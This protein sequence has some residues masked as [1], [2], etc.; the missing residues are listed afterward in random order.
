M[1][2]FTRLVQ[3]KVAAS[4]DAKAILAELAGMGDKAAEFAF[5]EAL[6]RLELDH[7]S[8]PINVALDKDADL[9]KLRD[10]TF[11]AADKEARDK[12]RKAYDDA[13]KAKKE[14]LPEAKKALERIETA[15]KGR[16][17]LK[18]AE[19]Q[20]TK[21]LSAAR[22][23]V[24]TGGDADLKGA[25]EKVAAATKS[26][27]EAQNSDALKAARKTVTEARAATSAK[28]KELLAA[29][30]EAAALAKE[31]DDLRTKIDELDKQIRAASKK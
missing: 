18:A 12:A 6:A 7:P 14:A 28:V 2:A 3:E 13:R 22:R 25:Q 19:A 29:N 15:K 17:D 31:R 24:E 16:A 11:Q 21:N 10:A 30:Q 23:K 9:A 20:A 4:P 1:A 27:F 5:Q 8:S 26:A